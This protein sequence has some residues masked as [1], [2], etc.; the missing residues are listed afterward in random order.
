MI[1]HRLLTK[2]FLPKD[3][4]VA[5]KIVDDVIIVPV[6]KRAKDVDNIYSMNA[7][8]ARIW[9]LMDGTLSLEQIVQKIMAEYEVDES[10][11]SQD[12]VEFV[13]KLLKIDVLQEV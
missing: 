13:T 7:T 5:R 11:A 2:R 1:I 6:R 3:S 9:E 8:G 4:V 10:T 12:A